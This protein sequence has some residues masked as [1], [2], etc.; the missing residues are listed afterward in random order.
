MPQCTAQFISAMSCTEYGMLPVAVNGSGTTYFT[1]GAWAENNH[2]VGIL[3]AGGSIWHV[4]DTA[5]VFCLYL[6]AEGERHFFTAQAETQ[7]E[8]IHVLRGDI[9]FLMA[10]IDNGGTKHEAQSYRCSRRCP[11]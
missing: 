3:H 8:T 5:G 11:P 10:V 9:D 1:D 6:G 2:P 4:T 7:E